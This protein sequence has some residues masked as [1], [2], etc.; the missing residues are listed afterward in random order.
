MN[1]SEVATGVDIILDHTLGDHIFDL[2]VSVLGEWD[3]T[4]I[5]REKGPNM[6][7]VLENRPRRHHERPLVRFVFGNGPVEV[8]LGELK[9]PSAKS[10]L[11]PESLLPSPFRFDHF[12]QLWE[13]VRIPIYSNN[14]WGGMS[15]GE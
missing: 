11:S 2:F 13:H 12:F 4:V 6:G 5:F 7:I 8:D 10:F 14:Q 9:G 1:S 15:M 3:I